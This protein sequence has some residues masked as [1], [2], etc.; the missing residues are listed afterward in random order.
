MS[1][2]KFQKLVRACWTCLHVQVELRLKKKYT[3]PNAKHT[4]EHRAQSN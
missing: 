1:L 4:E 3:K 2:G